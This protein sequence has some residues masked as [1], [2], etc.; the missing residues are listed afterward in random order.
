MVPAFL[1][2]LLV[3][4]GYKI[5]SILARRRL[6]VNGLDECGLLSHLVWVI[7]C[8]NKSKVARARQL[9]MAD[10]GFGWMICLLHIGLLT[11][12]IVY[13]NKAPFSFLSILSGYSLITTFAQAD[14]YDLTQTHCLFCHIIYANIQNMHNPLF[15]EFFLQMPHSWISLAK[16]ICSP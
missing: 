8:M 7:S 11:Y 12:S 15:S 16:S 3:Q 13:S 4:R 2:D 6:Q 5:P 10:C 9:V 14:G 1:L